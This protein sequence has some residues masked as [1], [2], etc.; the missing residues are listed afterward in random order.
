VRFKALILFLIFSSFQLVAQNQIKLDYGKNS[1]VVIP[2]YSGDQDYVS[3]KDLVELTD[4][5]YYE[6]AAKKKVVVSISDR[7][8]KITGNNPFIVV[9]EKLTYQM[10]V[11]CQFI[12]GVIFVPVQFF[13]PIASSFLPTPIMVNDQKPLLQTS[14]VIAIQKPEEK[15]SDAVNLSSMEFDK[16]TNGLLMRVKTGKEFRN[17]DVEVWRNKNWLYVT[18]SGAR[19]SAELAN[20]IKLSE[21]FKLIKAALIFQHKNSV[22]F[23]FQLNYEIPG[24]EIAVDEKSGDIFVSVRVGDPA[25]LDLT[26][27]KVP[28]LNIQKDQWKIDKICLDAGH[29]GKDNGAKGKNGTKEKDVTLGIVLKLGK[30]I[31]KKLGLKVE[32]TRT[33]DTYPT[34][35]G[36]TKFANSVNAKLFVSVHCN[37][38]VKRTANG[39]ETFFLSPSRTEEALAVARLEN[40]VID[41]EEDKHKYG[42]FTDEKFILSNI[43]QS[44]F[45]KESEELASFIQ[46][47]IDK[48]VDLENR[49]VAQ[50]PFYVLMGAS[51]P[52][53]LVETAFISNVKEEKFLKSEEGQTKLAE[54]IFEGIKNFIQNYEQSMKEK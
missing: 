24:Q 7:Q 22:Q 3:I 11:E 42:D 34:L 9:D 50:A 27:Q 6:N 40:E 43:M 33:G 49:G 51:M 17:E 2:V 25:H 12:D 36:R 26:A 15:D 54:G 5:G 23:S 8:F 20:D 38:N 13:I 46:K 1:A 14:T 10:P 41:L 48:K 37:A 29:G 44:V 4:A 45:V 19:H 30:L 31:E 47:G 21:Q 32:Y 35:H 52:S 28:A 16:K 39:F 18:I 53:V